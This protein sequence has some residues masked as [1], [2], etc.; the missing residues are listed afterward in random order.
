MSDES[1]ESNESTEQCALETLG[2]LGEESLV[3]SIFHG[4]S[5]T[6][7]DAKVPASGPP[8]VLPSRASIQSFLCF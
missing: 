2:D 4:A 1:T 6:K 5:S 3:F 7:L 8:G